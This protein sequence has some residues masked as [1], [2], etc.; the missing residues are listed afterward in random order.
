MSMIGEYVRLTPAELDR[1]L[2]DPDWAYGFVQQLMDAADA[3][4]RRLDVDKAWDSLDHLLRRIGFPVDV[5]HGEDEIQNAG[6]W[7][8]GP[9]SYLTPEQVGVAAEAL[10][11]LSGEALVAGVAA[12]ELTGDEHYPNLAAQEVPSWLTYVVHH[13]EALAAFLGAAAHAGDGVLLWVD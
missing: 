11:A 7:G 6:D 3:G 2:G 8:Y 5:V 1:A 12:E 10:A 9:P 13:F 4:A